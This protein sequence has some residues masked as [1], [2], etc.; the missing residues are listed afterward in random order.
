MLGGDLDRRIVVDV[1]EL[2]LLVLFVGD[3]MTLYLRI[4]GLL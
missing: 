4:E 1:V 2:G 3:D